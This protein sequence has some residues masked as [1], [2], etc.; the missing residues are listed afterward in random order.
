MSDDDPV[1]QQQQRLQHHHY[2]HQQQQQQ[3]QQHRF[4]EERPLIRR[5]ADLLNQH[6]LD[7][8]AN[9][10]PTS[11]SPVSRQFL[12]SQ[13]LQQHREK[14]QQH[15]SSGGGGSSNNNN[16]LRGSRTQQRPRMLHQQP[17]LYPVVSSQSP[18]PHAPPTLED[19]ISIALQGGEQFVSLK[20]DQQKR[21]QK[22]QQQQSKLD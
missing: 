10:A 3:Q 18:A 7:G 22:R 6:H 8:E 1:R 21:Q 19:P 4:S 14:Q 16:S 5:S 15:N 2:P 13:R 17:L 12:T 11:S 20:I 9:F